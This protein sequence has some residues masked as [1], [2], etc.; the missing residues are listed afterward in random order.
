MPRMLLVVVRALAPEGTRLGRK[1]E[2]LP[3][4]CACVLKSVGVS[5]PG[6]NGGVEKMLAGGVRLRLRLKNEPEREEKLSVYD[7]ARALCGRDAARERGNIKLC[8][9]LLSRQDV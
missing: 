3:D 9:F 6:V 2:K 4:A 5:G 8:R 1:C 7:A